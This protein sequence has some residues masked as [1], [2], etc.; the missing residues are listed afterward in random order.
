VPQQQS[1]I[2]QGEDIILKARYS[3]PPLALGERKMA[4]SV[5]LYWFALVAQLV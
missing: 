5:L 1:G 2:A 4:K 3:T